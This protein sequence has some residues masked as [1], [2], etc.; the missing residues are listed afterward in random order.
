MRPVGKADPRLVRVLGEPPELGHWH[1]WRIAETDS[2]YILV[3]AGILQRLLVVVDKQTLQ[4]RLVAKGHRFTANWTEIP[5][6]KAGMS[7]E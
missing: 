1:R 4:T 5:G 3:A 6:E 2:V 7:D